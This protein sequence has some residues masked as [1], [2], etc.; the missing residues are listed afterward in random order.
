[1]LMGHNGLSDCAF[2]LLW[3][4]GRERPGR[5]FHAPSSFRD[6][7]TD[8]ILMSNWQLKG[9]HFLQKRKFCALSA[10]S[11][12]RRNLFIDQC[13]DWPSLVY[14][15]GVGPRRNTTEN[16]SVGYQYFNFGA[17]HLALAL[18]HSQCR[19]QS[20][21]RPH[22]FRAIL[23]YSRPQILSKYRATVV[24]PYELS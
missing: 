24:R 6:T 21:A 9:G 23:A 8:F 11:H 3:R 7:Q 16:L 22:G 5:G 13:T 10:I 18:A 15:V 20:A 4:E 19:V 14:P 17:H 1:M 2:W 12:H